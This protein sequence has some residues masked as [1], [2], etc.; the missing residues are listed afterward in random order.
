[1]QDPTGRYGFREEVA[2][3]KAVGTAA[4]DY[5]AIVAPTGRHGFREEVASIEGRRSSVES[6]Q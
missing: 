1:M 3:T 6:Q 4:E 5:D 2:S